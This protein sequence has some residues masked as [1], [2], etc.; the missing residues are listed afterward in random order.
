M[1]GGAVAAVAQQLGEVGEH[2]GFVLDDGFQFLG[3]VLV[4]GD[5]VEKQWP[6]RD[7]L[8]QWA[9][10][11]FSGAGMKSGLSGVHA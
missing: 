8:C 5:Y 7:F 6:S 2:V 1:G 4:V 10:E 11:G 3:R 9:D